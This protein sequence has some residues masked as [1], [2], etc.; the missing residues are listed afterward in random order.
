M[1]KGHFTLGDSLFI[2]SMG[3]LV[4]CV[5]KAYQLFKS[6]PKKKEEKSS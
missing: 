3:I 6:E 4:I 1:E 2:I 5:G